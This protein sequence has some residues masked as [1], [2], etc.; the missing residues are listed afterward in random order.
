MSPFYK[1]R[2]VFI[3]RDEILIVSSNTVRKTISLTNGLTICTTNDLTDS[4]TNCIYNIW[5]D[6]RKY[7]SK[8][9][10]ES[11]SV[12][13][14]LMPYI[15]LKNEFNEYYTLEKKDKFYTDFNKEKNYKNKRS[16]GLNK[17]IIKTECGYND[18][19]FECTAQIIF[20]DYQIKNITN[21]LNFKGFVIDYTEKKCIHL[22]IVFVLD[23]LKKNV[24]KQD[25]DYYKSKWIIKNELIDKYG[26]FDIWSKF[27]I[28]YLVDNEL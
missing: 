22:G 18:P 20:S 21:K 13:Y 11:S 17:H 2:E 4:K 23:T 1:N 27:I 6:S 14:Q 3:I 5:Q 28:D 15:I 9:D 24:P 12:V 25:T 7:I 8:E 16:L 19:I 10:A 26:Q